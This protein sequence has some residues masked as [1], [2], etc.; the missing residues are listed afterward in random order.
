MRTCQTHAT[1]NG[2]AR[3]VQGND[4]FEASG[5]Q[6]SSYRLMAFLTTGPL[7]KFGYSSTSFRNSSSFLAAWIRS[8][9]SV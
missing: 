3:N 5:I 6:K 8:I 2:G 1:S 7:H 4:D 9:P